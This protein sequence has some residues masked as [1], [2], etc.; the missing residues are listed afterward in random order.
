MSTT[1]KPTD[2]ELSEKEVELIKK[3]QSNDPS[4]ELLELTSDDL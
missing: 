1:N 2:K 3:Y 4:G